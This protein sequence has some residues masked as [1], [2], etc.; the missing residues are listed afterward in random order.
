MNAVVRVPQWDL[1]CPDWAERLYAGRT[2]V[3]DLPQLD[4]V[5]GDRAV[6]VFNKLRLADVPLTP[7]LADACGD[8]FRHVVRALFGARDPV[9]RQRMIRELFLLVPKKNS[10]TTYGA[11]LMLV[12]LL[13][14]ERPLATFIMTAPVQ[15]VADMAFEAAA[16]AIRLD[17]VLEKKLHIRDHKKTIVHR[18]TGATLEI[19]T[20]DPATLTGQKVSGG[21]LID[22]LHVVAKMAKAASAIRQLRGGMLPFPEAFMAFI[23]TQSEEAPAGVFRAELMKARAIRDGIRQGSMLPVLYEFP[24]AM[25]AAPL[26]WRDPKNWPMV[27]PNEGRS[28]GIPR[29]IEEFETASATSEEELRAWAS[30][31]LNVEIGLALMAD[32]WA[33]AE[34]WEAQDE[35]G[36]TLDT[37]LERSEV[38]V[39]GIDGGGLDDLLGLAVMGRERGTRKW[40]LWVHGWAH[41]IVLKRRQDIAPK[42]LDFVADGD[43]TLVETPGDD[44]TAV[45]AIVCRIRDLGLLPDEKA[46][47]VDA[48]GIGDIVDTLEAPENGIQPA[49]I[50]AIP[51]GYKM[52][53]AIKTAERKVAGGDL[54]HHVS[55]FM[56]WCVG[57]AKAEARGNAVLITKQAAGSAKIDPLLAAFNAIALMSL[58]PEAPMVIGDGYE[59][60]VV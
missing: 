12:A 39:V 5:Q 23:T 11:L 36:L 7:A 56:N 34:Y 38:V 58:N 60:T 33:G 59:L 1:S 55:R 24:K 57:N 28:I 45:A 30:Q 44:V 10:K 20:F 50:V 6:A 8:W 31:H 35:E 16:G 47:G 49:Q 17:H 21:A 3:P 51:Q 52:N 22:E 9:T 26:V 29:L 53:G 40:L 27:T 2:L 41:E 43:L 18:E 13:L 42:L 19:M 54:V 32:A 25:Q 48:L 14:N 15:D 37:L 4:L 46:V